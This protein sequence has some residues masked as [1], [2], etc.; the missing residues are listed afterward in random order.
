MKV[1]EINGRAVTSDQYKVILGEDEDITSID[2]SFMGVGSIAETAS[3]EHVYR[4]DE[5]RVWQPV[6]LAGG[7][8]GGGGGDYEEARYS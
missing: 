3:Y 5:N 4:L 8:G 1:L 7:G 2:T 6:T